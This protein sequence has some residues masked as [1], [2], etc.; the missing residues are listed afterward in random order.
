MENMSKRGLLRQ[1]S[2]RAGGEALAAAVEGVWKAP[3]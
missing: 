2:L 1:Y 3:T